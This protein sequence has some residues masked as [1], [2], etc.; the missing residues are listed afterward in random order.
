MMKKAVIFDFDYTLGDC[1]EGI[2]QS[3]NYGMKQMGL[4][5][6]GR[7]EIVKTIGLSLAKTYE[8]LTGGA[9]KSEIELFEHYFVQKADEV[10][11]AN[12]VVYDGVADMLQGMKRNKIK[13]G[14]V[15]TKY[16]YRIDHI[17][18]ANGVQQFIDAI[19]GGDDVRNVK[20]DPEGILNIGR[21][22]GMDLG[23]MLYVGDNVVDAQ[24]AEAAGIDFIAVLTGTALR[25]DFQKYPHVC[26]MNEVTQ[27]SAFIE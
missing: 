26:I 4:V 12:T 21:Q 27:I 10:M 2:V 16:H 5:E 8:K 17:L 3:V 9:D 24:A 23:E 19:V 13:T 7:N 15:T 11:V 18:C 22:L 6:C 1:T 25:E 14:I 20:P